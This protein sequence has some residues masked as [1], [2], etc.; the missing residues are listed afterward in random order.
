MPFHSIYVTITTMKHVRIALAQINSTVGDIEGN[1][2]KILSYI[3]TAERER[4]DIV[5]FPELAITGYPPEDLLLKPQFIKDN[6]D[7]LERLKNEV[8]DIIVITG[9]VDKDEDIYNAAAIIYR[10][11]IVDIY[12]KVFLPN[13]GVFDEFRYFQ[14]GRRCP[15]YRMGGA[16]FGVSICE[17]IWYPDGPPTR[18]ALTGAEILININASPYHKGKIK[19][20]ERMLSTR[21][22]DNIAIVCYLNSV[23]GQDELV[24]DGGSMVID[25]RGNTIARA[26][27]FEEDMLIVD[28]D[29]ESVFTMRLHDTR[30]RRTTVL[31][32]K[33]NKEIINIDKDVSEKEMIRRN[34]ITPLLGEIEE[35]YKALI[36]G[37]RDYVKK[38]GFK[39]VLIG[40]SGGIDSALVTTI[41]VDAL[42]K[43]SVK[44]VFM[45]SPYTS[46]ESREDAYQLSKNLDIDLIEIEI[47]EIFESYLRKLKPIFKDLPE[48]V[49]EENIQAR[50]RGNILMAL[51]NKYG[52]LVLTTGNKSEMSVGYATLYGDMAGGF[53]VIK[54]VP[55]TL[56]YKLA[57]WRNSIS[58]VIPE[59]ILIKAPTA[60]LKKDQLD[61][62]TLP[63]Y[64]VLDPVLK[65]Y[66]EEDRS[67]DEIIS[68]GC[69]EECV[70]NIIRMV[71]RS[72]YKRRQA[73]PG[74]KITPRALGKDRRFPITN[75]YRS[76]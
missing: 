56:V 69:N 12:H 40:I 24:F 39:G 36:T 27:Q 9:F 30:R 55:K 60:E 43:E 21:A 45:P 70:K 1:L 68:L 19:E 67:F 59:R 75:A 33:D 4:A 47:T 11:N 63:P 49:T 44:G 73:P 22:T 25:E 65:A 51:S 35:V 52:Y 34:I 6:L 32:E 7:I 26:K 64:D 29:L 2:E 37:T 10:H 74:I 28:L 18:Q 5:V 66:I 38:N 76:F 50:I 31:L 23:G 17:D 16:I 41:A 53:A 46:N 14:A 13:Y 15:V 54:D 3:K 57:R 20:R 58:F 48:D 71:D 72:E 8:N 61:T 42:G 62:D